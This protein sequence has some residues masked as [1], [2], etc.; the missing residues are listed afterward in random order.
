MR[1]SQ[2]CAHDFPRSLLFSRQ[3]CEEE[4]FIKRYQ[5]HTAYETLKLAAS[6]DGDEPHYHPDLAF[7]NYKSA[8]TSPKTPSIMLH[9]QY[10][11]SALLIITL[12]FQENV[13]QDITQRQHALQA[14]ILINY[15]QPMHS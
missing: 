7:V 12:S 5:T 4:N 1:C 6:Q 15:H 14:A 3:R 8:P 10:L 11:Q 2:D 13:F 9:V